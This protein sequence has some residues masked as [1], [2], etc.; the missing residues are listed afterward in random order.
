MRRVFVTLLAVSLLSIA[1]FGQSGRK[2]ANPKPAATPTVTGPLETSPAPPK[3]AKEL[4]AEVDGERIYKSREADERFQILKKPNP[5]Y[6]SEARRH[7]THGYLVLRMILAAD[8]TVKHIEV[9]TGLP[10]GLTEKAMQV[11]Q[12]IKFKPAKKDGKPVSVWVEVEYR[13]EI[14]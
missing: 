7:H 5:T 14:Y 13:F 2:G 1:A 12:Q 9:V 3:A 4:P 8:E 11:A 10:D 6:T